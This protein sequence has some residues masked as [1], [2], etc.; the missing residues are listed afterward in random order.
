MPVHTRAKALCHAASF[1]ARYFLEAGRPDDAVADLIAVWAL[2]R[3]L[4]AHGTLFSVRVRDSMEALLDQFVAEHFHRFSPETL[5][6]LAAALDALPGRGSVADAIEPEKQRFVASELRPLVQ[7]RAELSGDDQAVI[8]QFRERKLREAEASGDWESLGRITAET[9]KLIAEAGG[10]AEGL[11][12]ALKEV[13]ARHT[14]VEA[15]LRMPPLAYL[16]RSPQLLVEL[17]SESNPMVRTLGRIAIAVRNVDLVIEVRWRM[18]HAA[19][20]HRL[21]E[22]LALEKFQD[23]AGAGSFTM[24]RVVLDGVDRGFALESAL[25]V[26]GFKETLVFVER[27]GSPIIVSG[28]RAGELRPPPVDTETRMRERYGIKPSGEL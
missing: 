8:V 26:R 10:T 3:N 25:Q 28:P 16:E 21:G 23:P 20:Q 13:V 7:L 15:L 1:R 17:E 6:A 4:S 22:P 5:R 14:A 24:R 11:Q 2:A 12:R 9:D 19:I 18:L 27:P